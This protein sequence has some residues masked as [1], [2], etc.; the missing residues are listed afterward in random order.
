[1][2]RSRPNATPRRSS[3]SNQQDHGESG[4][5]RRRIAA[6]APAHAMILL[7]N[8]AV[9]YRRL[10][11][12]SYP[13]KVVPVI[14]RLITWSGYYW[15]V[16][17]S[18]GYNEQP[19]FGPWSS[20][21]QNVWV[22]PE[23]ALH[24][25]ITGDR[26]KRVSAQVTSTTPFGYGTYRLHVH[27]DS[28]GLDRWSVFAMYT[29]GARDANGNLNELDIEHGDVGVIHPNSTSQFVVQPYDVVGHLHRFAVPVGALDRIE[30]IKWFPNGVR[31]TVYDATNPLAPP[32]AT[33]AFPNAKAVPQ[34]AGDA[35]NLSMW[36]LPK[37]GGPTV[38]PVNE[39]ILDSLTFTP[40]VIHGTYPGLS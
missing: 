19:S 16:R 25:R 22:D 39:A 4:G 38:P 35:L 12:I 24:L 1:M 32:I 6:L 40:L 28:A 7:V 13:A 26:G 8:A 18:A 33:W 5:E 34:F 27:L 29:F 10:L 15:T 11:Y 37:H 30:E 20:S 17:D 3:R 36:S 14:S 21:S 2:L 31:F 23:G 9:S